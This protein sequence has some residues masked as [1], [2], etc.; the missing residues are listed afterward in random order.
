[1]GSFGRAFG[2]PPLRGPQ[3]GPT[4]PN[5]KSSYLAPPRCRGEGG[6]PGSTPRPGPLRARRQAGE[7]TGE[8]PKSSYPAHHGRVPPPRCRGEGGEPGCTPHRQP[9]PCRPREGVPLRAPVLA[10]FEPDGQAGEPTGEYPKSPK[11]PPSRVPSASPLAPMVSE[12]TGQQTCR[13]DTGPRPVIRL[14]P[15]SARRCRNN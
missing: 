8:Y 1:M 14:P 11:M 2:G 4:T 5:L 12:P 9:P 6:K 7:P 10:H 15:P 3:P 13:S